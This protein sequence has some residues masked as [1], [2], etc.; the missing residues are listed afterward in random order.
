MRR[1]V[2]RMV[3]D[4]LAEAKRRRLPPTRLGAH[5]SI[6]YTFVDAMIKGGLLRVE[7]AENGKVTVLT[8][9]GL[10]ALTG[11][12]S[13]RSQLSDFYKLLHGSSQERWEE[14]K[15]EGGNEIIC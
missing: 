5:C 13:F 14:L 2:E 8:E 10:H 1:G 15:E 11:Y 6:N 3:A 12:E 4:V 9:K 7:H